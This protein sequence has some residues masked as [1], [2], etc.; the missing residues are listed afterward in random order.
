MMWSNDKKALRRRH[1]ARLAKEEEQDEEKE[2]EEKDEE[3]DEEKNEEKDN[4]RGG[5]VMWRL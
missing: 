2:K 3:K 1:Q 5:A 4:E